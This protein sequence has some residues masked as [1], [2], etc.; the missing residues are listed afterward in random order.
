MTA[1]LVELFLYVLGL[2]ATYFCGPDR[3]HI[4]LRGLQTAR[5]EMVQGVFGQLSRALGRVF[6]P[7]QSINQSTTY[8]PSYPKG[9]RIERPKCFAYSEQ[10]SYVDGRSK[11]VCL[12]E[13]FPWYLPTG[14]GINRRTH[15]R[16]RPT[17]CSGPCWKTL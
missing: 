17:F 4:W 12:D 14:V 3:G 15:L 8:G 7:T 6:I 13:S 10:E 5:V 9:P 16:T 11:S 1:S 2:C